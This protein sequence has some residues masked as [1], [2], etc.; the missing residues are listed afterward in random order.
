MNDLSNP[1]F[2]DISN[3]VGDAPLHIVK[4]PNVKME[5]VAL[6]KYV[7]KNEGSGM[8]ISTSKA[9]LPADDA[10]DEKR[11][12]PYVLIGN[13]ED[14]SSR[15]TGA[16]RAT[17]TMSIG[18]GWA[19][20]EKTS[21]FC[22]DDAIVE[23]R[24][25]I[26]RASGKLNSATGTQPRYMVTYASVGIPI[27]R[28]NWLVEYADA[29]GVSVVRGPK[30]QEN[31]GYIWINANI[32]RDYI[33]P[34]VITLPNGGVKILGDQKQN[35]KAA[36]M[37]AK[38]SFIGVVAMEI[39]LKRGPGFTVS[40]RNYLLSPSLKMMQV[41]DITDICSPPLNKAVEFMPKDVVTSTRLLES[42]RGRSANIVGQE[43]IIGG[44]GNLAGQQ[45]PIPEQPD[46]AH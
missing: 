38:Q 15:L 30:D 35:L 41:I 4:D 13:E 14:I 6:G 11:D 8:Y 31:S 46:Y 33:P 21:M 18:V 19:D 3:A 16:T 12:T 26:D 29:A 20:G 9:I 44:T 25:N 23:Y 45:A 24:K 7:R 10:D 2:G 39:N 37:T 17:Y 36:L 43:T 40:S 34:M 1:V 27:K 32:T 28:Y 42:L 5:M 22:F